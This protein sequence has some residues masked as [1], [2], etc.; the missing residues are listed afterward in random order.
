[1]PVGPQ[2]LVAIKPVQTGASLENINPRKRNC[3]F[4]F[5][6]EMLS[7]FE[8]YSQSNCFLDCAIK[9]A[10]EK[11]LRQN[12]L[13]CRLWHLPKIEDSIPFVLLN[14]LKNLLITLDC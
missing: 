10:Q 13:P 4:P 14:T 6:N 9:D 8:A 7:V 11:L 2:S 5:E 3:L 1:M 12:I